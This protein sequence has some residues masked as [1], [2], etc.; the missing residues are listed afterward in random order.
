MADKDYSF[1]EVVVGVVHGFLIWFCHLL[2]YLEY[3][4]LGSFSSFSARILL[5]SVLSRCSSPSKIVS[6]KLH[7]KSLHLEFG[8][9][10]LLYNQ[11]F[12]FF[13]FENFCHGW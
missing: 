9:E 3:L 1:W 4:S 6:Y 13:E 2:N 7:L 5:V 12:G 8:V 10:L 11:G